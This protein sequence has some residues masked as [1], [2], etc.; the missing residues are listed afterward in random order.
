MMDGSDVNADRLAVIAPSMILGLMAQALELKALGHP[1]IDLGI[2]EPDFK[3]PDHIKKAAYQ[4][5]KN[6]ETRYTLVAGTP[7]LRTAI[8]NKLKRDNN[9]DYPLDNITVSGGAKQVIFNAFMASLS[10]GDEV[11]VPSPNWPS[12]LDMVAI[13]DGTPVSVECP[14]R[15]RFLLTPELLGAAITPSTRWLVMNSPSNPTGGAYTK[16]QLVQIA[17]VLRAHKHVWVLSDDIY[18]HLMFQGHDFVSILNVAPDLKS[19]TLLVNGVSK[20]FAMTGWRIGYGAGPKALIDGMNVVQGQSSTQASSISQ[21]AAVAALNGPTDFF[22]DRAAEFE[23]RRDL[24]VAA[25]NAIQGIK[26]LSPEG[27]FYVFPSCEGLIGKR[28]P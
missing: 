17:K 12:Y 21:A 3:T 7:M 2:G 5:I 18:E 28:T 1:V 14:Q 23:A 8:R 25:L 11:I 6:D 19:R 24:V 15:D 16:T 13:A 4:A 20:V 22:A 27:A 9:L 10:Q 26:C